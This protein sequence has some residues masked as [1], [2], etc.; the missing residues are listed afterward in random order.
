MSDDPIDELNDAA[1]HSPRDRRHT[2]SIVA[3]PIG[4]LEDITLRA[5][6]TLREADLVLA[7]DTRRTRVLCTH[8]GLHCNLRAFHAHSPPQ[9]IE[10]I[11]EELQSGKHIALVTD[12]GTPL[13]SDPGAL[14]VA[15]ARERGLRVET[16]PGASAITAAL[17]VAA[18]PVDHFRFVGFLPR[19]GRRRREALAQLRADASATV[20]F[21]SP[22]R[23]LDTLE[24]LAA[25]LAAERQLSVCRE[26]TKLH[27]EVVRGSARE[28]VEHFQKA[29]PRGEITLVIAGNREA[30]PELDPEDL[31]ERI[32]ALLQSGVS[33]KDAAAQLA[34]E[35][36]LRKQELYARIEACKAQ[37]RPESDDS[38][39]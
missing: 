7:E 6:R 33:T 16:V 26:L 22:R 9:H 29:A 17:T 5:L 18:L 3:T 25:M 19:S 14:L 20:L 13:L 27:E 30:A 31:D 35:T 12:A 8:H 23:L 24:E 1:A 38:D 34:R 28:L 4:N 36:G 37:A 15:A 11:V 39:G 10:Q 2:L 32:G 21:E